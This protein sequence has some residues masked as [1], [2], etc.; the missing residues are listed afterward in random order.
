[1]KRSFLLLAGFVMGLSAF[2]QKETYDLISFTPPQG[3]KKEE[4]STLVVYTHIDQAKKS[5]CQLSIVKSTT[6]KG[7]MDQDFQS[8]WQDLVVKNYSPSSAPQ[9]S[10]VLES[11]GFMIQSGSASFTFN[12]NDCYAILTSFS[13]HGRCASIV[14]SSNSQE[15]M[16]DI[17]SLLSTVEIIKP[18]SSPVQQP[19]PPVQAE[20]SNPVNDGYTFNTTNFDNGW[21]STIHPGWVQASKGNIKAL[22]HYKHDEVDKYNPD[23]LGGLKFAW[24]VL[25]APKYQSISNLEF[26]T[27]NGWEAIEMAEAD[28]VETATGKQVRVFF[29]KKNYYGGRGV[30]LEFITPDKKTFEMEFGPLNDNSDWDKIAGVAYYNRFAVS[31]A[32][33]KGKWTNEYS[34]NV[35]YVNANTGLD[36]GMNSHASRTI[37]EFKEGKK[38]HWDLAM[39]SGM[40]GNLKFDGVKSNGTFSMKGNWQLHLSDIE[41]DP[42]TW[43]VYFSINRGFRTLWIDKQAFYKA[44]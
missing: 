42:K 35:Q 41:G 38:Y 7:S 25:G 30:Y 32:D 4:R 44:K 34:G 5:W 17:E 24:S 37:F 10:E 3:W 6:S 1:M 11:E 12:N 27:V 39:A 33:L 23:L 14:V 19:A 43:D 29:F 20:L 2:A 28:A 21:T 36:A 15:Y 13:G 22:I 16:T 26:K 40:V 9:L 18:A 8:E 31:E